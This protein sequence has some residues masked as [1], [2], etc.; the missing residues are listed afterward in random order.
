[1][2]VRKRMQMIRMMEKMEKNP[3]FSKKIGI[4]D[5]SYFRLEK[6]K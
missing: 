4:R 5:K 1:M 3:Q 2:D 6:E